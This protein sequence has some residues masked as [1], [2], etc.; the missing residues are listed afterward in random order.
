[1]TLFT[2]SCFCV[3]IV[4][5]FSGASGAWGADTALP[6]V[7]IRSGETQ[8]FVDDYLIA[9]Q[10]RLKRTLRQPVKDQGGNEPLLALEQ[11]FG[12]TKGTLEAN[13]TIVYDS[14]RKK[15][16]MFALAFASNWPGDSADRV[17]LYRFTSPDAMNW[18]KGD[19]G[20]AGMTE[21]GDKALIYAKPDDVAVSAAG[22]WNTTL[23]G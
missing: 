17:R 2:R 16:V 10:G 1:M 12:E 19:D 6:P 18:T 21:R 9:S 3:V 8:L 14:R 5:T 20:T 23:A 13:G 7:A 11:E 22:A 4:A 15:W